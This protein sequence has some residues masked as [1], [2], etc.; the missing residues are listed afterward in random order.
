MHGLSFDT[1]RDPRTR[2]SLYLTLAE[3]YARMPDCATNRSG[4]FLSLAA[5]AIRKLRPPPPST[6]SSS[7][8][9]SGRDHGRNGVWYELCIRYYRTGG[10]IGLEEG[11]Y[12]ESVGLLARHVFYAS[13]LYGLDSVELDWGYYLLGRAFELG[14][15]DGED[16]TAGS[17]SGNV[18]EKAVKCYN[19]V[20][21]LW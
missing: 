18:C 8:S 20:L 16:T 12:A 6:P 13:K 7:S 9:S 14:G 2:S 17:G 1:K 3:S 4:Y 21:K 11:R 19:F 5:V 10:R 15:D